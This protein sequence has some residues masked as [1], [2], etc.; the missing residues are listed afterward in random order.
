M[1]PGGIGAIWAQ[2][3]DA[4]GRPVI[5]AGGTMPWHLPGDLA[6]FQELTRGGAVIMGRRTW[7]SLPPRFRPL[8]GR[9]NVV[10]TARESLDGAVVATTL[11]DALAAAAAAAP[12]AQ[13]WLIGGATV[14][15]AALDVAD[16]LEVTEIDLE[17]A[18]D[19]YAPHIPAGA[20]SVVAE[21]E[22]RRDGDGPRYRFVTYGRS[23]GA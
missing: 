9:V 14:F 20:W 1:S 11:A 16:R 19:T 6:R 15:A 5:G 7:E 12:G 2:A 10:L 18:G 13:C 23:I 3:R 8:P 21:S 4:S 17:I 22:W